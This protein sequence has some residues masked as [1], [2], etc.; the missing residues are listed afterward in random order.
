MVNAQNL[1]IFDGRGL[2]DLVEIAAELGIGQIGNAAKRGYGHLRLG[3][4]LMHIVQ[5]MLDGQKCG[6]MVDGGAL[7]V[8]LRQNG[9][10]HGHALVIVS[11]TLERPGLVNGLEILTEYGRI[12]GCKAL[13]L[14]VLLIGD[15]QI[16]A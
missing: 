14:Q 2:I 5:R 10:E 11:R 12:L 3:K 7:L 13:G 8:Q 1:Q 9:I 6:G 4:M 16:D 15:I